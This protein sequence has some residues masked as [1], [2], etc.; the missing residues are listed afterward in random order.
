MVAD[1]IH[2]P[3]D[4]VNSM[5][6]TVGGAPTPIPVPE[7]SKLWE[8]YVHHDSIYD[9]IRR[10]REHEIEW[11]LA[12]DHIEDVVVNGQVIPAAVA[13]EQ[14]HQAKLKLLPERLHNHNDRV[15]NSSIT[16]NPFVPT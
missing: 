3:L 8:L 12:G 10:I 14:N 13:W 6:L 2:I 1:N 9:D 11:I 16:I 4:R 7:E 15:V 5:R